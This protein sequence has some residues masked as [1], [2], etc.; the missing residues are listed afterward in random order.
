MKQN[1]A[2]LPAERAFTLTEILVSMGIVAVLAGL[3]FPTMKTAVASAQSAR[4]MSNLR[5]IG[6]ALHA[7]ASE[8]E[9][10][11]PRPY[12]GGSGKSTTWFMD[13]IPYTGMAANSMGLI[14]LPRAAGIFLC[15]AKKDRGDRSVAYAQN[16]YMGRPDPSVWNFKRVNVPVPAQTFMIVET[17]ANDET[18]SPTFS[19][20][21]KRRHP[22]DSGNYLFVDGHVENI[23]GR[24]TASDPRWKWFE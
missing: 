10:S 24:V 12:E 23:K 17:D 3:L 7:Y 22:N 20:E 21:P 18:F 4:C 1:C 19:A 6:L 16:I 13:L 5:Q 11:F 15:P 14:P 8:N 2:F 9:Q